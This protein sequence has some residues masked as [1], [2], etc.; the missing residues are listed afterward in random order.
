MGWGGSSGWTKKLDCTSALQILIKAQIKV[1]TIATEDIWGEIDSAD[2]L[3]L[4]EKLY[5]AKEFQ[6]QAS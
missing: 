5:Q 6:L 2:D 4:Y 1:A 3:K